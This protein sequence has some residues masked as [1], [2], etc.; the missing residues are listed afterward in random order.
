MIQPSN[1]ELRI[2]ISVEPEYRKKAMEVANDLINRRWE[3]AMDGHRIATHVCDDENFWSVG[4]VTIWSE[5]WSEILDKETEENN[6]RVKL[7]KDAYKYREILTIIG[8]KT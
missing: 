5:R 4:A 6:K 2:S 8:E 1:N 3:E 7:E